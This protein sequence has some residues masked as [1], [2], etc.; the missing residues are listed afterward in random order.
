MFALG[1]STWK[2]EE[3]THDRVIVSPAPG[4]MGRLPFWRG[5]GVGRPVE[6]GEKQGRLLR[7][8]ASRAEAEALEWLSRETPLDRF[9]AEN[10]T[11]FVHEQ[12]EVSAVPTDETLVAERF[13]DELGD[14]RMCLLSPY[15][16][17][18]HGP[19]AIAARALLAAATGVEA[20]VSHNDDGLIWRSADLDE[21]PDVRSLL[22]TSDD[23]E[24]IVSE[25]IGGSALFAS[26]FRENAGRSLLLTRRKADGRNPL[27]SQRLKAK[28]LLGVVKRYPRFPIVLE[29]YRQCMQDIFDLP[30]AVRLLERIETGEV[31]IETRETGSPSPF[32]TD[33]VFEHIAQYLYEVDAPAAES[34]ARALSLDRS[35]LRRLLG[36]GSERELVDAAVVEEVEAKLQR[37]HD[38]TQ[39]RDADEL[40]DVLREVGAFDLQALSDRSTSNPE[41]W[42]ESLRREGRVVT[43]GNG[44]WAAIEIAGLYGEA[45]G[46][47]VGEGALPLSE[48]ER[49]EPVATLLR[50]L[51]AR[52]G[53]FTAGELASELHT[54][55][56]L[57]RPV[58]DEL[59]ARGGLIS[60]ELRPG[61]TD[62]EWCDPDVW[63][64]I[65]RT[66]LAR[67]RDEIEPVDGAAGRGLGNT[68]D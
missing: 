51:A 6:L 58:L 53:P 30:G 47:E 33:V 68:R 39:A 15:G 37:V 40:N 23:L 41:P 9:A 60:G 43:V 48:A 2:V 34:R 54:S 7:E 25:H 45:L 21:L 42:L 20:E 61:G 26:M 18:V 56:A 4:E 13:R 59:V 44:H 52:R 10:L 8:I 28:N 22:P 27:W 63:R 19:L 55:A 35:L 16:S 24:R 66:S 62:L 1:A 32:A 49:E 36:H 38:G 67:L 12:R 17:R 31:R 57:L 11:R 46:R 65:K 5:D 29:T 50:L 3:I 14:W 64:R